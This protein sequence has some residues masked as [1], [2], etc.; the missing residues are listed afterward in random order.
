MWQLVAMLAF[1]CA[2]GQAFNIF[3]GM[4]GYVDFG[5]VAFMGLGTY[6]M[7]LSIA[8]LHQVQW[9]G[10]GIVVIGLLVALVMASLLSIAVGAVALRLRGAY[11][12]IATIGVNEGFRF[13]IEGAKIWGG[14]EGIIFS[15]QLTKAFGS[16]TASL[17]STWW[18]DIFVFFIACIAA[19]I[20]IYYMRG[21]IGYAL[22]AL[23][24][25]EDAA[26]VM[27]INVTKYKIIAFITSS[28]LAG[29]VGA[30]AW[31]L[32]LTYVFPPEAFE[33]HY[34][35]ECIIIVL[36]GGAGTLL[37]PVVG[38]L[39][40]GLSKYWLTVIV[41]GFQ[42]LI[43]AP[44]IILIIVAFPEGMIGLLKQKL[45]GTALRRFIV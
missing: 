8:S 15:G 31:A 10:I 28:S 34:T 32:K 42:L 18:A 35:V 26:K 44:L 22:T 4:T 38:G 27:G 23:R 37:G 36:L 40:Y 13:L 21:R 39:V 14:S 1:Y 19:F 9:L 17:L 25:D 33:I 43:F 7:A 16:E 41:P 3:L 2:I 30:S 6:G 24:E 5:Y 20:T 29:L 45:K 11:F 12:A